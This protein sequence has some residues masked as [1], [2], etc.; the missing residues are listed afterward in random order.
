MATGWKSVHVFVSSTFNDMHGERDY[1]IKRVFPQL[2]VWCERRKLRLVD[3]DLR[4]GVTEEDATHNRNVVN[5]CLNR[6]DDCRPFFV[7][8][9]GQRR[10]WV[11]QPG[12]VA[13]ETFDAFPELAPLVGTASV[14]ELEILH[15]LIEPF[16]GNAPRDDDKKPEYYERVKHA[17]FYLRDPSY[18]AQL[19]GGVPLLRETYTNEG[20]DAPGLHDAE[21]K[22]W[23]ENRIRAANRPVHSYH[24]T[25]SDDAS[26]PELTL[27]LQCPSTNKQNQARWRKQWRDAGVTLSDRDIDVAACP[28]EA[29]KAEAFNALLTRGRLVEFSGESGAPLA[30]VLLRDLQ[31]AIK[32]RHPNHVPVDGEDA[33]QKEIDQQEEFLYVNSQGFIERDGDFDALDAYLKNDS[34]Q[35]FALTA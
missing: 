29:Q 7:C 3:I 22:E 16:H 27:P 6:I 24:A 10:G 21:L 35:M 4:W 19:P 1:L 20:T 8:F 26:T 33:L 32:D 30:G 28:A 13:A 12:D 31:G 15:A 5:T 17:F 23:R 18:L 2:R 14:T 9:L 34:K 25:W 11:P